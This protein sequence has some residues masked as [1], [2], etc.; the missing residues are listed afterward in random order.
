[1]NKTGSKKVPHCGENLNENTT[2]MEAHFD[3]GVWNGKHIFFYRSLVMNGDW[4]P[5]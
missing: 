3:V 2:V 5:R 1:M 4:V